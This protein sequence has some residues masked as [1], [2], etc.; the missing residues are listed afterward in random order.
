VPAAATRTLRIGAGVYNPYS[1][2]PTLIAVEVGALDEL[3]GGRVR[4][5]IGSGIGFASVDDLA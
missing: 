4:V 3:S 5:A 1:R 2:H